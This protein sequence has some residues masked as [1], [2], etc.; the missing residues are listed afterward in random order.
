MKDKEE[1]FY[2]YYF[3]GP[4][5]WRTKVP[6]KDLKELMSIF[7]NIISKWV[8]C[9]MRSSR[10]ISEHEIKNTLKEINKSDITVLKYPEN[11]FDYA[12]RISKDYNSVIVT[13]SFEVFGPEINWLGNKK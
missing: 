3:W 7:K 10:S 6:D 8:L 11:A 5:L 13:G 4:L 9:E 1:I 2:N 12:E